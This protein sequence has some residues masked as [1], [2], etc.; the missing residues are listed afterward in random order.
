MSWREDLA[1]ISF[2]RRAVESDPEVMLD[3][4]MSTLYLT[5]YLFVI[6]FSLIGDRLVNN[7]PEQ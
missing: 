5:E 7:H 3:V 1:K 6:S 4:N 2:P